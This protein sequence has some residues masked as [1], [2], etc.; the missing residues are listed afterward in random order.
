MN[1]RMNER[2]LNEAEK[3]GSSTC[4]SSP[5]WTRSID[6]GW[7]MKHLATDQALQDR[8]RAKSADIRRD[9]GIHPRLRRQRAVAHRREDHGV[10]WACR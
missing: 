7:V 10:P 4:S 9:R 2:T 8:L 6:L 1:G 3:L 5:G